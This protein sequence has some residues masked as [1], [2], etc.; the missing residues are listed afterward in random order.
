MFHHQFHGRLR[1]QIRPGRLTR[2][3]RST[4][5]LRDSIVVG[6]L[7]WERR[8]VIRVSPRLA[9]APKKQCYHPH[10]VA[11]RG[12]VPQTVPA[13]AGKLRPLP[14]ARASQAMKR[15]SSQAPRGRSVPPLML[16]PTPVELTP[17]VGSRIEQVPSP[18]LSSNFRTAPDFGT[19]GD[20][21]PRWQRRG[22]GLWQRPLPPLGWLIQ[23][24]KLTNTE[25]R[26]ECKSRRKIRI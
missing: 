10:M 17:D 24:V 20:A 16:G 13:P 19:T 6:W 26:R 5:C 4:E 22:E 15:R 14:L 7:S 23:G 8:R 9:Q 1:D 18:W 21:L 2:D 11:E 12:S 3:T 25:C